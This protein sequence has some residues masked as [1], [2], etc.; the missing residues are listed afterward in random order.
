MVQTKNLKFTSDQGFPKKEHR[1]WQLHSLWLQMT[2]AVQDGRCQE[3]V[4]KLYSEEEGV[5]PP[6]LIGL[7]ASLE[8]NAMFPPLMKQMSGVEH[9]GRCLQPLQHSDKTGAC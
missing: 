2:S 5:C 9:D 4:G 6:S 3:Y 7:K 1:D 8:G